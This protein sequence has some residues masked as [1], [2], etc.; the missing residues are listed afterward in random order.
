M[1]LA[2]GELGRVIRRETRH[3]GQCVLAGDFDLPHVADVEQA[4]AF[5]H[6]QVLG[7]NP[8]VFNRHVPAAERDHFRAVGAMTSVKRGLLQRCGGSLFHVGL[9]A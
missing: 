6:R 8:G 9:R 7:D 2:D 1:C 4:G 3:A 5:A